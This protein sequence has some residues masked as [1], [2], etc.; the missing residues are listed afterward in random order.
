M[1]A[2]IAL[3]LGLVAAL[4]TTGIEEA[5]FDGRAGGVL[6]VIVGG[7]VGV[8]CLHFLQMQARGH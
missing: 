2:L 5:A 8:I 6:A 1:R 3:I 7:A 4:F